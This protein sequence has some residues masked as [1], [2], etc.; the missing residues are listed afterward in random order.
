MRIC[1]PIQRMQFQSLVE[2]LRS[3]MLWHLQC[4][5]P[6]FNPWVRKIPWR[7]D[8]QPIPVCLPGESHGQ[9][10]LAG[11]SPWGRK[12]SDTTEQLSAHTLIKVVK[13][14]LQPGKAQAGSWWETEQSQKVNFI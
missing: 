10:S 3:Y 13:I 9:R 14:E 5:S 7:R 8:W 12:E 1:L 4:R 11:Y 6:R 2:D